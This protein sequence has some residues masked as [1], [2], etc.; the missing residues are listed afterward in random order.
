MKEGK[1]ALNIAQKTPRAMRPSTAASRSPTW[2]RPVVISD[3][4]GIN[5]RRSWV[6]PTNIIN[7]TPTAQRIGLSS[8]VR[9]GMAGITLV[10]AKAMSKD[11]VTKG[12]LKRA[13]ILSIWGFHP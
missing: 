8:N 11:G 4:V 13:H 1:K 2:K 10:S 7:R 12:R 6:R 3:R 5:M 9:A